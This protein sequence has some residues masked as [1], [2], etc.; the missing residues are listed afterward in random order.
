MKKVLFAIFVLLTVK[1]FASEPYIMNLDQQSQNSGI[2]VNPVDPLPSF[3]KKTYPVEDTFIYGKSGQTVA[4]FPDS[5]SVSMSSLGIRRLSNN[6]IYGIEYNSFLSKN[7]YKA[8]TTQIV[9]GYRAVWENRFL[10]YVLFQA[11]TANFSD[12]NKVLESASGIALTLDAGLDLFKFKGFKF[13]S[14]VRDT[15]M[16]FDSKVISGANF[17]DLYFLFGFEF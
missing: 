7:E 3:A 9:V 5:Q 16:S 2:K 10:P 6:F 15:S 17:M 8:D 13:S 11:G 12:G 14:G 1:V 4:R